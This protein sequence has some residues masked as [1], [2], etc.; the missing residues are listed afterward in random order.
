MSSGDFR[1][2]E[3]FFIETIVLSKTLLSAKLATSLWLFYRPHDLRYLRRRKRPIVLRFGHAFDP[4]IGGSG[5]KSHILALIS[6]PCELRVKDESHV[7]F[8]HLIPLTMLR[9]RAM[10]K[11]ISL[12]SIMMPAFLSSRNPPSPYERLNP[13]SLSF[14]ILPS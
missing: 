4:T 3:L 14:S 6:F 2:R 9:R 13:P 10:T 5:E 12:L 11:T 8:P 7:L 1:D